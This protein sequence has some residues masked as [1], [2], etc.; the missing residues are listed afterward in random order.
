M[1]IIYEQIPLKNIQCG[2]FK[3]NETS[4]DDSV[5]LQL[6][7]FS[8][9]QPFC[10][11]NSIV[12]AVSEVDRQ[13]LYQDSIV[14]DMLG[15]Q[16]HPEKIRETSFYEILQ[17]YLKDKHGVFVKIA[18]ASPKDVITKALVTPE[19][20]W[21][22]LASSKRIRTFLSFLKPG[23]CEL[24]LRPWDSRIKPENEFRVFIKDRK[25]VA[26]SQQHWNKFVGPEITE[27]CK[28]IL[29]WVNNRVTALPYDNVVMDM[30]VHDGYGYLIEC[31]P[32]S[33]RTGTALFTR[34]EINNPV[35]DIIRVR[36]VIN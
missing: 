15:I 9:F 36:T 23:S 3:C 14:C 13:M 28:A 7:S 16:P 25:C 5:D 2:D 22:T 4:P 8:T 12:I 34:H 32:W 20:I 26:I 1:S 19:E 27:S 31:N 18:D 33:K 17:N 30:F 21:M 35:P 11:D 24:V 29:K 6:Y 10:N